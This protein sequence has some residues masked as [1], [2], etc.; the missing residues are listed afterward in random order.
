MY[1]L[2]VN[3]GIHDASACLYRDFDLLAS[4]SLE[5]LTRV[6]NAGV[7]AS[8]PMPNLAIDECLAIGG[9]ERGDVDVL[10]MA[11]GMFEYQ[12][13]A[14]TG[15]RA[16]KQAWRRMRGERKMRFVVNVLRWE[17]KTDAYE[18]FRSEKFLA[19]EGFPRARLHF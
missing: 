17:G 18:I 1:I 8:T 12:D 15:P 9:I 3:T 13:Y 10:A 19:R 2:G 7:T 5:R 11:R 4:V 6:K 14:L 16:I